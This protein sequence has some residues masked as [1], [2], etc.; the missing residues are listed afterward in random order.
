MSLSPTPH[1]HVV[2]IYLKI[3]KPNHCPRYSQLNSPESG[4]DCPQ[5]NGILTRH[6]ADTLRKGVLGGW[7]YKQKGKVQISEQC[8]RALYTG[9]LEG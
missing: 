1:G 4:L 9:I 6:K 3:K 7:E 5:R 8:S 2:R